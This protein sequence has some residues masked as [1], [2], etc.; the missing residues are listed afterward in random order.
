MAYNP[1]MYNP[2]ANQPINGLVSVSGIEGAKAYP[3]PPN[4]VMPVFD[5]NE[6]ILYIVSSDGAGFKTVRDFDF[7]A[8]VHEEPKATNNEAFDA[9]AAKVEELTK[10][11]ESM[12]KPTRTRKVDNGE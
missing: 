6:D 2:Y 4:S 11:V 7:T 3:L 9:L 10:A 5:S 1:M 12:T 8:R